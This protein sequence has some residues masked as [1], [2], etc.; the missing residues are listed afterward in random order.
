MTS[1]SWTEENDQALDSFAW[2][3]SVRFLLVYLDPS[4]G[5][6]VDMSLPA[7]VPHC[8]VPLGICPE[9]LSPCSVM[10]ESN[11]LFQWRTA[12]PYYRQY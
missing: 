10:R 6:R 9:L 12:L 2:D 4:T 7:E 11:E 1:E 5:L 8:P 3:A